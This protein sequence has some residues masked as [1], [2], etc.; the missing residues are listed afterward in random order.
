VNRSMIGMPLKRA[1][2]RICDSPANARSLA[3]SSPRA[4]RRT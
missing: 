4:L 2:S 3:K 1:P